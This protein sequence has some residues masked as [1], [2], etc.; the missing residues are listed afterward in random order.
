M[1]QSAQTTEAPIMCANR[2]MGVQYPHIVLYG[3]KIGPC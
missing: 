2:R 1:L 3:H